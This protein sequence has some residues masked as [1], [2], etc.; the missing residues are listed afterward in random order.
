MRIEHIRTDNSSGKPRLTARV[1][2]E[3]SA[4]PACDVYFETESEFADG[5]STNAHAFLIA[6]LLPAMR[7]GERRVSVDTAIC[8]EL[9]HGLVNAMKLVQGWYGSQR[10]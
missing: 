8:P 3:D 6:C 10:P 4:R 5:L 7:Y 2:W 1:V 9:Q